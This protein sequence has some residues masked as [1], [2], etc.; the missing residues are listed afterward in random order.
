[1]KKYC[2]ILFQI[3][4]STSIFA[5]FNSLKY[6]VPMERVTL[7]FEEKNISIPLIDTL[8]NPL[9][10]DTLRT[11]SIQLHK[12]VLFSLPLKNIFIT[13]VYGNRLHPI[14]RV[15]KFHYGIDLRAKNDTIFSIYHSKIIDA[16]YCKDLGH[17]IKTAFLDYTVTYG[18]LQYYFYKKNDIV[19]ANIPIGITGNTGKST[20][21]HLHFS[22]QKNGLHINP[23]T[24][25]K[26]IL[27]ANNIAV[28]NFILVNNN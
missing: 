3:F 1:M 25:I 9:N 7:R 6:D 26:N 19:D 18:H 21:P 24:F 2:F 10:I 28:D 22:V 8:S 14:D 13:S 27:K 5:Q 4:C 15:H 12:P 23:V 16:G 11:E 20:A 17:Y